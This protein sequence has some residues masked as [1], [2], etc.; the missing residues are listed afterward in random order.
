METAELV[1][2]PA[3]KGELKSSLS[4]P[5]FSSIENTEIVAAPV[6]AELPVAYTKRPEG[7]TAIAVGETCVSAGK[8][9]PGK[10]LSAPVS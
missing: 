9:D 1:A 3:E 6:M 5:E 2:G 7:L 10:G 4:A 8:G